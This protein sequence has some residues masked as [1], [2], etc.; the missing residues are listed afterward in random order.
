MGTLAR[1]S[2]HI[3]LQP[4]PSLRPRPFAVEKLTAIFDAQGH[5]KSSSIVGAIQVGRVPPWQVA[6]LVRRR[7]SQEW[8]PT[9]LCD[10]PNHRHHVSPSFVALAPGAAPCPQIKS[11]LS[12]NP[13][14][15]VGLSESL[16][17]GRRD[18]RALSAHGSDSGGCRR[19]APL[20]SAP[21]PRL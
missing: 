10:V 7:G 12:G 15:R 13:P 4:A 9:L 11:Y 18:A 8:L 20:L 21:L 3:A 14:I 5:Q 16:I 1:K 19:G 2:A 17:L 6:S